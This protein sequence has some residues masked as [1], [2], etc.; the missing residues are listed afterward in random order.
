MLK[1]LSNIGLSPLGQN[2]IP[3]KSRFTEHINY[4]ASADVLD[5]VDFFV[6]SLPFLS[7]QYDERD[8]LLYL[9]SNNPGSQFNMLKVNKN[10]FF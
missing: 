8:F 9:T 2:L 1:N 3:A 7:R 4:F 10:Q 5:N 6:D